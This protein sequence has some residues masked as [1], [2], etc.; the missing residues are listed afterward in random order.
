MSGR[1]AE[2]N[3]ILPNPKTRRLNP[4][5]H[6][7]LTIVAIY[8]HNDGSAAIPALAHSMR[9]L[10]G[11]RGLLISIAKPA[12]LPADIAWKPVLPMDHRQYSLFV[13]YCLTH[14]IDTDFALIVQDDGWVVNGNN[15][16]DEYLNYDYIGAPGHAAIVDN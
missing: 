7:T 6:D 2:Y 5:H 9:E 3:R 1:P 10:P 8:G 12:D 16:R 14:F 13:M 15:W 11:A 4:R